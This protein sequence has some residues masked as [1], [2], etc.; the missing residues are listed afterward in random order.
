MYFDVFCSYRTSAFKCAFF[1]IGHYFSLLVT[2]TIQSR[3]NAVKER[4]FADFFGRAQPQRNVGGEQIINRRLE[5]FPRCAQQRRRDSR[6]DVIAIMFLGRRYC[7][8]SPGQGDLQPVIGETPTNRIKLMS[9]HMLSC[10][11]IHSIHRLETFLDTLE[12]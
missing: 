2:N 4:H 1:T 7:L 11:S 3:A 6:S 8:L 12:N 5:E 10:A 9:M